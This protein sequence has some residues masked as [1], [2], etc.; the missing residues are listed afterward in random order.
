MEKTQL[1]LT[2]FLILLIL[3]A[4]LIRLLFQHL[5][6]RPLL[7]QQARSFAHAKPLP[8]KQKP[9]RKKTL[10]S[11]DATEYGGAPM[12][13]LKGLIVKAHGNASYKEISHSVEQCV[14]FTEQHLTE[15]I[16]KSLIKEQTKE[17]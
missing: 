13:G 1:Q 2:V 16:E 17:D 9:Q 15:K 5:R 12:L 4:V 11:L 8:R 7:L 3:S 14:R 6:Y 10:K